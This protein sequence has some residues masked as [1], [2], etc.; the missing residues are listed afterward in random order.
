MTEIFQEQEIEKPIDIGEVKKYKI[1]LEL[2]LEAHRDAITIT[3]KIEHVLEEPMSQTLPPDIE[4]RRQKNKGDRKVIDSLQSKIAKKIAE[5]FKGAGVIAG[6]SCSFE[7][8]FDSYG[9]NY[10]NSGPAQ[11]LN[12]RVPTDLKDKDREKTLS[13]IRT[14]IKEIANELQCS[15]RE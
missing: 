11:R 12:L 4:E 14:K 9:S 3:S 8:K 7:K 2:T 15:F 10:E 5:N 13:E 1:G 6:V